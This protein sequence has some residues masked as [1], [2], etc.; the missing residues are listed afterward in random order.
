MRRFNLLLLNE[1]PAVARRVLKSVSRVFRQNF[2]FEVLSLKEAHGILGKLNID[3][4][5]IDLDLVPAN[6]V[7]LTAKYPDLIV[8]GLSEQPAKVNVR[9]DPEQHIILDKGDFAGALAMEL[10]SVRRELQ[11]PKRVSRRKKPQPPAVANDF[12]D[13][14]KLA[15]RTRSAR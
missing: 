5:V 12:K 2:V 11:T 1:N 15:S 8:V 9:F 14:F 10:K 6:L 13:F 7:S 3:L 4:M